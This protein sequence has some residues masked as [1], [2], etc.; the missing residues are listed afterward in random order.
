M[1]KCGHLEK[2]KDVDEDCFVSPVVITVKSDKLVKIALDSRKLNDSC[3]K[4]RPHMPNM[5][6]LLNQISVE[7]TRDRT[8]QL[9]ISKIDLDYAYGQMKL[10]EET[11]RQCVFALTGGKFSGYYRF[12]KGFYGHAD[13]PTIFQEKID[14]TL[15]YC[16]P[17][18]LDDIIIVTRGNKQDHEK[19]LFDVLNKLEKAGYRASKKKS[20]FFM[21]QTKWLGHEID[22][23]GIKP[24]EEK[25]LRAKQYMAKFL[26]KLSERTDR[27]R[28]LLKK[29]ETCNWGTEQDEEFGK[30]KQILTEGPC[31]AHYAKDKDNIVTTDASTTGL[32]NT[33]WQKQDNGNIKP[34]AYGNRY[35]NDTEKKYSI[36]ELEILAVV[37]GL[38]TFRFYLYGKKVH[39]YT[40]HQALEPLIKRNRSNKQYSARLTRWLDR[41]THFDISIQHTAGSNL[42]FTD[43]LSRNPVEGATPEENYDEEYVINILAEQAGLNLKY[44]QLFGDQSKR[45]KYITERIKN[46]SK[47]KTEHKT[48]QSQ[49]NRMF[50]NKNHVNGTE[51]NENIR[52]VQH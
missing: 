43:Y 41:L 21:K 37:W 14:R 29:N 4:M 18:W 22:E 3:I 24:N 15:G 32:G 51:Q 20:E 27:L 6:E 45:N 13:I 26:P 49:S 1:I 30:I 17:A 10:S 33:L 39:L 12:K 25:F 19:K 52:A 2:I 50:E 7:I 5:E 44:G 9:F 48:D 42:K 38:E 35:L 23:N 16:T 34:I 36:G 47:H 46:D 40:D 28:K 8:M 11:S 31:F